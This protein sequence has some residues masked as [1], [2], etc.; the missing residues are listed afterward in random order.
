V[1]SAPVRRT[2]DRD[3][4]P[5]LALSG[6]LELSLDVHL[7]TLLSPDSDVPLEVY[8]AAAIALGMPRIAITDHLDFDPRE[9]GATMAPHRRRVEAVEQLRREFGDRVEILL[10]VEISYERRYE[11]EIRAHLQMNRYDLTIGSVHPGMDSPFRRSQAAT[12]EGSPAAATA[13]YFDEVRMGIESGLFDIVGHLD[14]VRKYVYPHIP[15]ESFAA[16]PELYEPVLKAL[17]ETGTALEINSSGWRQRT[18]LPYPLPQAVE[19]YR[20]LGGTFVVAGSDSHRPE[21]FAL[22]FDRVRT[23]LLESGFDELATR[24]WKEAG[25]RWPIRRD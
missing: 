12:W 7:H 16:T 10:G 19:R 3:R 2:G 5:E 21:W 20:A 9:L 4:R 11:E 14:Y 25:E 6:K 23:L 24:R 18:G 1:S 8:P 13:P 17:V 22:N 15:T